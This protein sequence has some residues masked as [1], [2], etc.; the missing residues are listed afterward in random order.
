M[1]KILV[2]IVR[3]KKPAL[4]KQNACW[5]LNH[6]CSYSCVRLL[7]IT[8]NVL[9]HLHK[10]GLCEPVNF[11][12]APK[13]YVIP[14]VVGAQRDQQAQ[15]IQQLKAMG[16]GLELAWDGISDSPGYSAKYGGYNIIEQRLNKVLDI[17]LVQVSN[18]EY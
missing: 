6:I 16:G 3:L 2:N 7:A 13:Y 11:S 5:K 12:Q 15:P 1:F 4:H 18:S 14:T 17:Q 10:H 9:V 8:S